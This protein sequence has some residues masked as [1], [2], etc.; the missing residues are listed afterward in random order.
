MQIFEPTLQL[1][2]ARLSAPEHNMTND[3]LMFSTAHPTLHEGVDKMKFTHDGI[4][5][6]HAHTWI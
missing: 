1:K 3:S 5:F 6:Y 2:Q 4:D